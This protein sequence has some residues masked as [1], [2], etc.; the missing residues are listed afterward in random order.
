MKDFKKD[1]LIENQVILEIILES[2]SCHQTGFV[3]KKI[4]INKLTPELLQKT[5]RLIFD[6]IIQ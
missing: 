1:N 2:K 3:M 5:H 6:E 4:S